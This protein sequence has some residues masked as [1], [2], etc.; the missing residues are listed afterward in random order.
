MSDKHDNHDNES[1]RNKAI[2]ERNLR[3][4]ERNGEIYN[5]D[6]IIKD[7]K[8]K[9]LSAHHYDKMKKEKEIN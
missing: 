3:E 6:S 2:D 7:G 9:S 4:K 8:E 5:G 1:L